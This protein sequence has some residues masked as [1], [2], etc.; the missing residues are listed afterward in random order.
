M[1]LGI[2][3]G[4]YGSGGSTPST[5]S[6]ALDSDMLDG[7]HSSAFASSS[8]SHNHNDLSGL[9]GGTTNQYYHINQLVST[10]ISNGY[11]SQGHTAYGWG[12]HSGLYLSKIGDDTTNYKITVGDFQV[13]DQ[14]QN[15]SEVIAY[16]A[17]QKA[18]AN[19]LMNQSEHQNQLFQTHQILLTGYGNQNNQQIEYLTNHNLTDGKIGLEDY[20]DTT[21]YPYSAYMFLCDVHL[22]IYKGD[23]S[24]L[25]HIGYQ[26]NFT[27]NI[28]NNNIDFCE[29][30]GHT[31]VNT[32]YAESTF[33][34][35]GL[36]LIESS[37]GIVYFKFG[38]ML[39][40]DIQALIDSEQYRL[41]INVKVDI[42]EFV[43]PA[44]Q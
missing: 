3:M 7:S 17:E 33:A 28:I 5:V 29:A 18:F 6:Y 42:L 19:G 20:F 13:N 40:R 27:Y 38:E 21:N 23:Y 39:I 36:Q 31:T 4:S 25:I 9:Q 2:G 35:P 1:A 41:F 30:F 26:K 34:S 12:N 44:I 24:N 8:H 37:T 15:G 16:L 43:K 11:L 22:M 14:Q 10:Y 32:G